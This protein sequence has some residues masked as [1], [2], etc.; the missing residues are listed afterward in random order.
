MALIFGCF[1]GLLGWTRWIPL[2]LSWTHSHLQNQVHGCIGNN[3]GTCLGCF[4]VRA[5]FL[6]LADQITNYYLQNKFTGSC[7][8]HKNTQK[9]E[10]YQLMCTYV[11]MAH[12]YIPFFFVFRCFTGIS[13]Q[14]IL[15]AYLYL[16]RY[17]KC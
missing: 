8:S 6:L 14:K 17:I 11:H 10:I 12:T 15:I 1:S 4:R 13:Y 16:L 5:C 2:Y 7:S 9:Q 3:K